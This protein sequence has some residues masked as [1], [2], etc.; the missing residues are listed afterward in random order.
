MTTLLETRYRAVLR[1]LPAYYRRARED[2]MV[3]TYLWDID[4]ETADQSRPTVGEV[5]SVAALAVRSR[6]AA[7]GAPRPY[8]LLGAAARLFVLFAVL[9]QA[10]A[11]VVDRVLALAW[12]S[13]GDATRWE[14]FASGFTGHGL[15]TGIISVVD[16][17]LPLLWTAGYV[18]LLHDRRH[19]AR[20]AVLLAA[21]PTAWP[22]VAPLVDASVPPDPAYAA[23]SA[24]LAWLTALA[25]CAAYH[26]DAPPASLPTGSP[27]L[28][29][30]ACCVVMAASIVLLPLVA[31]SV[32]A[33][34]TCYLAGALGW[35]LWHAWR[36]DQDTA[37]GA[38]ALAALG[39]L[40]LAL[41]AAALYQWLDVPTPD[42]LLAG[43]L[44]QTAAL[45]VLTGALAAVAGRG[46]RT[47]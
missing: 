23:T 17:T 7:A 44:G 1:L 34:A 6:L 29:F 37:C 3:E 21:L 46:L 35:L 5:A 31:D 11:A 28:L 14:M 19:L 12:A 8:A 38:V 22:L 41:R 42:V 2:E 47:R 40:I 27:G 4:Q 36:T 9:L 33:P 24:L 39:L 20:A 32:W 25:L 30:M 26:R 13:T 16:W 45:V 15:P 10:A 43:V 18:A